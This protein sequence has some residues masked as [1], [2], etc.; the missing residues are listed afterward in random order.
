LPST[1]TAF[2]I[3]SATP[4][5]TPS[6]RPPTP[7]Q[8]LPITPIQTASQPPKKRGSRGS[9]RKQPAK[10]SAVEQKGRSTQWRNDRNAAGELV[11]DVLYDEYLLQDGF[12]RRW[13]GWGGSTKSSTS[14]RIA[15]ELIARGFHPERDGKSVADKVTAV[16]T[17]YSTVVKWK[18]QT[19]QGVLEEEDGLQKCEESDSGADKDAD[20]EGDEEDEGM[21]SDAS[22]ARRNA[23]SDGNLNS[24]G[25][26]HSTDLE[27]LSNPPPRPRPPSR[28]SG[29][30]RNPPTTPSPA[31]KAPLG[32]A[33][34]SVHKSKGSGKASHI[35]PL[36]EHLKLAAND[37]LDLRRHM[38]DAQRA[39]NA[40]L[41]SIEREKLK[42]EQERM[43]SEKAVV[44]MKVISAMISSGWSK[45]QV[46]AWSEQNPP[47]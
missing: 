10:K 33:P 29:S 34:M 26:T 45:E 3:P 31:V 30:A 15:K 46:D 13:G 38:M 14:K 20:A 44:R 6:F 2:P 7:L 16:R 19:G 1:P 24:Q 22:I 23:F 11:L 5:Q 36:F 41:L 37:K 47:A 21:L 4:A 28:P 39:H 12:F 9:P 8:S 27:A 35:T 17:A 18:S 32:K 42:I 40:D 43:A 25:S